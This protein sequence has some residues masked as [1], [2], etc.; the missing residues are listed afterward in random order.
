MYEAE[1]VY[2]SLK[3]YYFDFNMEYKITNAMPNAL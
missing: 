2:P 1:S 3:T